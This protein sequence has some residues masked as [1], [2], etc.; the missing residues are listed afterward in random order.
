MSRKSSFGIFNLNKEELIYMA[1][2]ILIGI[3]LISIMNNRNQ[4]DD[5]GTVPWWLWLTG[6][7]STGSPTPSPTPSPTRSPT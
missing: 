4:Y 7:S 3:L 5:D 6:S 1:I 2:A